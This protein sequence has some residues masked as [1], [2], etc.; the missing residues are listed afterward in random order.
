MSFFRQNLHFSVRDKT[1]G[2]DDLGRPQPLASLI[3]FIE[4]QNA[5]AMGRASAAQEMGN[6]QAQAQL[7]SGIVYCLSRDESEQVAR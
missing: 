4:E 3:D 1:Y 7:P 5:L 6:A 2:E